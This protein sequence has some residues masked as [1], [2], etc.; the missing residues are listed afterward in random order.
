MDGVAILVAAD[1][2]YL[3]LIS[4]NPYQADSICNR[5]HRAHHPLQPASESPYSKY[6]QRVLDV[7][8]LQ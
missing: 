5:R 6:R 4:S 7:R 1:S 2:E 3:G 8:G